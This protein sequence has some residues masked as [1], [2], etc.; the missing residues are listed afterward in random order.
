[1]RGPRNPAVSAKQHIARD[2]GNRNEP[3]PAGH[4]RLFVNPVVL[5]DAVHSLRAPG[6]G[7]A[8]SDTLT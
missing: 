6:R 7:E 8:R 1:M 3:C 5:G 2:Y 4:H